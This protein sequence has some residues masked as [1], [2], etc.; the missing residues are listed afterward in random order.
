MADK[1]GENPSGNCGMHIT[2]R[3]LV[4]VIIAIAL[5][6]G[7]SALRSG[8]SDIAVL[9]VFDGRGED[10]FATLWVA[11]DRDGFTWLRAARPDRKWL[12]VVQA[13][14][15]VEVR[16]HGRT[17]RYVALVF[18]TPEARDYVDPLFRAKYGLADRWREWSTGRDTIPIRLQNR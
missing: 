11:D 13:Q 8:E 7:W 16:R 15:K 5:A 14:P 9:R 18:D 3:T 1:A 6:A 4:L 12:T 2:H 17:K 10:V